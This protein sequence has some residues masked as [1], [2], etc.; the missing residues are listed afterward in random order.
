[1]SINSRLWILTQIFRRLLWCTSDGGGIYN[2][3]SFTM[4]SSTVVIVFR[5]GVKNAPTNTGNI[6]HK[7]KIYMG[8][9]GYG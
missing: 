7:L 9:V 6:V 2:S 8:G 5:V 1:M 3:G 4:T